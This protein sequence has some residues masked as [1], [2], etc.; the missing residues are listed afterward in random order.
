VTRDTATEGPVTLSIVI[1]C[2]NAVD[3]IGDQLEALANQTWDQPFE[4]IVADNGSTDG[5]LDVV[6]A[7]RDKMPNLRIVDASGKRGSAHA[8]NE[9]VRV[10]RAQ[11]LAFC[12]ADDQVADGWVAA[13]GNALTRHDFVASRHDTTKLNEPWVQERGESPLVNELPRLWYPPYVH[14]AASAGLGVRRQLHEAIGG[15]DESMPTLND[16]DYCIRLQLAGAQLH[17]APDAL[18]H[19]RYRTSLRALYRQARSYA[20]ENALLQ[21]RYGAD[22][23]VPGRWRW[24]LKG[25]KPIFR[26]LPVTYRKGARVRMAWLVGWQTG[27]LRGSLKYRVLAV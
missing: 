21:K 10:A 25:W 16:T 22:M 14:H 20:E 24:P 23:R 18:I 5:S 15:F 27:R 12:D 13:M 9:G 11:A 17:L 19:Y 2:L 4:V 3:T 6:E 26:C 1:P 7:Y 8:R